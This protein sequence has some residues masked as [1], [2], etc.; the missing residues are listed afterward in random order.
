MGAEDGLRSQAVEIPTGCRIPSLSAG[1]VNKVL[2]SQPTNNSEQQSQYQQVKKLFFSEREIC[3]I[4]WGVTSP[5]SQMSINAWSSRMGHRW[6]VKLI[7]D[8]TLIIKWQEIWL[9]KTKV[10]NIFMSLYIRT[11]RHPYNNTSCLCCF[12][13]YTVCYECRQDTISNTGK[14]EQ[15]LYCFLSDGDDI[16]IKIIQTKDS[17]R[18]RI[19]CYIANVC[20]THT[21]LCS[22]SMLFKTISEFS[23][24]VLRRNF[25]KRLGVLVEVKQIWMWR[26]TRDWRWQ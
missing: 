4:F 17:S 8:S 11:Y 2:I 10:T 26:K 1:G 14:L 20:Y 23:C 19:P 13:A 5:T 24:R 9:T 21:G 22:V 15:H 7:A 12:V 16:N 25:N 18:W 3:Q 6:K